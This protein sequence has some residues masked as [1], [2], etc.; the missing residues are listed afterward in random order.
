MAQETAGPRRDG[1]SPVSS[2][3]QETAGSPVPPASAHHHGA[4]GESEHGHIQRQHRGDAGKRQAGRKLF[5]NN[6]K[7][8]RVISQLKSTTL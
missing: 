3:A 2:I 1:F 4:A 5:K 6:F 8:I 7:R